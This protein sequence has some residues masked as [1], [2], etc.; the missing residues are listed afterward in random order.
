MSIS[1]GDASDGVRTGLAG[2]IATQLSL[3]F[4]SKYPA[5]SKDTK[6]LNSLSK[7]IANG[8]NGGIGGVGSVSAFTGYNHTATTS[9][10]VLTAVPGAS[11]TISTN[12]TAKI[13][14]LVGLSN[15]TSGTGVNWQLR[16]LVDG[17]AVAPIYAPFFNQAGVHMSWTFTWLV[18]APAAGSHNFSLQMTG[19]GLTTDLN[20][21][22]SMTLLQL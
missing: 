2:A 15:Y 20:D 21:Y 10:G 7:G 9:Y 17:N 11:L 13:L 12:G 16:L 14:V 8:I 4:G 18:D 1:A 5:N 6:T 19:P 22:V 3:D